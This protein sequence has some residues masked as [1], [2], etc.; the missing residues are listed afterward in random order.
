MAV[1][2][3][4]TLTARRMVSRLM[5]RQRENTRRNEAYWV[6]YSV[7]AQMCDEVLFCRNGQAAGL[8]YQ[9][10]SDGIGVLSVGHDPQY[11]MG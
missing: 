3:V 4:D 10:T 5:P 7:S 8:G 1:T 6:F 11:V 9:D 2:R